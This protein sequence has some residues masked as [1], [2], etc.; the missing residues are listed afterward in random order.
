MFFAWS[1]VSG[2]L[3]SLLLFC[4]DCRNCSSL[5]F[6]LSLWLATDKSALFCCTNLLVTI[7]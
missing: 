5:I 2:L 6:A 1:K 3:S 7:G 4:V